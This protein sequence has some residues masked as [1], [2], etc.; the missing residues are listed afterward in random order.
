MKEKFGNLEKNVILVQYKASLRGG[1]PA[2]KK[3]NPDLPAGIQKTNKR[4]YSEMKSS[5]KICR[6]MRYARSSGRLKMF[7]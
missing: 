5:S 2:D 3:K 1:L 7:V 6:A 4:H